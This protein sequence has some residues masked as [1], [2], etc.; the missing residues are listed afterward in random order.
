M[1]LS[2]QTALAN[3]LPL[4]FGVSGALTSP[5]IRDT[6]IMRLIAH[7]RAGG[8]SVF[9]TSPSYGKGRGEA[10]LGAAFAKDSEAFIMTKA[11]LVA[12]RAGRVR[13]DFSVKGIE[14][15]VTKSLKRLK[16][17]RLDMLWLHG[18]NHTELTHDM[19]TL[20]EKLKTSGD[21]GHIGIVGRTDQILLAHEYAMFEAAMLPL[22]AGENIQNH[23]WAKML[24]TADKM[25]FAIEVLAGQ[26]LKATSR[27]G[28]WR[29]I[30]QTTGRASAHNASQIESVETALAW[31][32]D[33]NLADFVLSSTTLKRHVTDN[34]ETITR[35]QDGLGSGPINFASEG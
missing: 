30:R 22:N 35:R 29:Q 5:L 14:R 11:G 33:Q 31:P 32:L 10:C 13:R 23:T 4:A 25:V 28:L 2:L 12:G 21:V 9:D 18:P 26:K 24:R 16:R 17:E 20:L 1:T 8:I 7:A 34:I 19:R 3:R 6:E 27:G 15:S